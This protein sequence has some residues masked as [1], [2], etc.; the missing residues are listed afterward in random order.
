MYIHMYTYIHIFVHNNTAQLNTYSFFYDSWIVRTAAG[1]VGA[2]DCYKIDRDTTRRQHSLDTFAAVSVHAH[3]DD[4][5]ASGIM[6]ETYA[7]SS[8]HGMADSQGSQSVAEEDDTVTATSSFHFDAQGRPMT[9]G[10]WH[11]LSQ[12]CGH[13]YVYDLGHC[14]GIFVLTTW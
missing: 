7:D 11:V 2:M 10:R 14:D 5:D 3:I 8:S 1:S 12:S 4:K 6:P 9:V 13:G